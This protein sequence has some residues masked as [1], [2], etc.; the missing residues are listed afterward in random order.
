MVDYVEVVNRQTVKVH[1]K[2]RGESKRML[3]VRGSIVAGAAG[4]GGQTR[5][6]ELRSRVVA[7]AA[8]FEPRAVYSSN[9]K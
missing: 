6:R 1:L 9:T 7:G 8:L 5:T 4:P 3:N 2:K